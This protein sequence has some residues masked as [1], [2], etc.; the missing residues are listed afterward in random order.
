MSDIRVAT[1]DQLQEAEAIARSLSVELSVGLGRSRRILGIVGAPGSGKSTLARL[2]GDE[3]GPERCV[4]VP[5]DGFH[6]ANRVLDRAGLLDRKGAIETF[7]G[8]GFVAM[9]ERIRGAVD[10]VVYAPTYIRGLEE[11]IANAIEVPRDIGLVIIEGNYLLSEIG[12]WRQV[13]PL[14]DECWFVATPEERRRT[15]L[16][17]RHI[18][19]GKARESAAAWANGPDA[20]NATVVEATR[21]RAD[22]VIRW[23]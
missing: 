10:P 20:L 18:Q 7:D 16:I 13:R 8:A 14:L 9:L 1:S 17:E 11:P 23:P 15:R 3:L 21:G 4:I 22:R 2:I 19:F 12:P 6:L 5:M